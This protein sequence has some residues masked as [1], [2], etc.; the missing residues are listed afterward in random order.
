MSDLPVH[1]GTDEVGAHPH[2]TGHRW[3]DITMAISAIFI[4]AVSLFVA[5]EHGH[6]EREL[7]AASS[8]PFLRSD[9]SNAYGAGHH[10]I[11]IG[12][13]N[14][15]VGPAKIRS[16]EMSLDGHPIG[17]PAELL[18]VCCGVRQEA[19][20]VRRV[21]PPGTATTSMIDNTVLRP[22]EAN[23]VLVIERDGTDPA[24]FRQLNA[25]LLRLRFTA[26][27]CS[28]L[29]QCWTTNLVSITTQPVEQCPA[30]QHPYVYNGWPVA[31]DATRADPTAAR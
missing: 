20:A 16:F 3:F 15:G 25:S 29:D 18:S 19:V 6:T 28:T 17:S 22:G 12:V 2:H 14:G 11:E 1:T 9:L 10:A 4:S 26:C 23:P 30:P 5:I 13:S 31:A 8:W 27:Y 21:L 24:V 7:V